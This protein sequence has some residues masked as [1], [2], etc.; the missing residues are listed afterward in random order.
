MRALFTAFV[1]MLL[2]FGAFGIVNAQVACEVQAVTSFPD[3]ATL[4]IDF[5][6]KSTGVTSFQMSTSTLVM[7]FN[8]AGLDYT[9]VGVNTSGPWDIFTDKDYQALNSA[10]GLDGGTGQGYGGLVV[11][12]QGHSTNASGFNNQGT[13]VPTSFTS[14]GTITIPIT[15]ASKTAN[16]SWRAIGSVTQVQRITN[17]GQLNGGGGSTDITSSTT[18]DVV[19]GTTPLP[20]ELVNFTGMAQG[21]TVNLT[22]GTKTE[23]NNY[24]F[25]VQRKDVNS[26]QSTVSSWAKVGFVDGKGTTNAPQSYTY[27]DVVKTAGS[28][29]YRLKQTNRDGSFSYSPEVAV[30][31]TLT[32]DDYKLSQNYPNPFNPTTKFNFA[33]KTTQ[34]VAVKVYNNLGQE[35][36]TL[37]DGTVPADQ[38]QEVTFDGARLAS[39]I[40]FYVLRSQDRVD[41]RKMLMVK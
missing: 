20:V 25:E 11:V 3:A 41:V 34:H 12:F 18:F 35:V 1:V 6:I 19:P 21:R 9:S 16:L 14:I 26:D 30:K 10:Q 37:F 32:A 5:Q 22:W 23:V 39:G 4:Q 27:A 13:V 2:L 38:I 28:F 33:M 17:P 31:A 8:V 29:S 7:N 24:G 40:Y 36:V 15:D